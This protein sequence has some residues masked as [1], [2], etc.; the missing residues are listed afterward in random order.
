MTA[1]RAAAVALLAAAWIALPLLSPLGAASESPARLRKEKA[2]LEEMKR[3]AEKAAADLADT[4]SKEKLTRERMEE[5]RDRLA[6]Q[7]R[8]LARLDGKLADLSTRLGRTEEEIRR[9]EAERTGSGQRMSA[10]ASR[11]FDAERLR[12]GPWVR[13]ARDE[14]H[15]HFA[16]LVLSGEAGRYGRL[17]ADREAREEQKAGLERSLVASERKKEQEL[18]VGEALASRKEAESRRLAEIGRKKKQKEKELKALRGRIAAMEALVTRIEKRMARREGKRPRGEPARF[19]SVPGGLVAPVAGRVVGRFGKQRDPLF[20]VVLENR[21]IEIE[22]GSGAVIRAAGK[23]EVVFLGSV[24]GFGKVLILQHGTGLFSV[25]GK[26]ESFSVASGQQVRA[27][28][29]VGRLPASPD[30]KSVLYLEFRAG[31]T[32]IDPLS[33]I[34]IP[35]G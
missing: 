31:G 25:Y 23:G 21:G 18:S 3:K 24:N 20:D 22:A 28:E 29:G 4:M 34:S 33:V 17:S 30:G 32:A 1:A 19:A 12:G 6:R 27:G 8:L 13:G 16:R 2:R 11:V 15:R 9:I 35:R 10:G 26:A 5:L 14:R 7:R